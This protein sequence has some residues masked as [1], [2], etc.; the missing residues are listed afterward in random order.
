MIVGIIAVS[1]Q[2][3]NTMEVEDVLDKELRPSEEIIPEIGREN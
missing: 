1:N 2:E 3:S